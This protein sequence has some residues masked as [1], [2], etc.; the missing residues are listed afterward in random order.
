M[1]RV[2]MCTKTHQ[3]I[4]TETTKRTSVRV[5]YHDKCLY[6]KPQIAF[7][8]VFAQAI[9][10]ALYRKSS[11]TN[12]YVNVD[13]SINAAMHRK[14]VIQES[15]TVNLREKETSGSRVRGKLTVA[16]IFVTPRVTYTKEKLSLYRFKVYRTGPLKTNHSSKWSF[17]FTGED[18]KKSPGVSST[19]EIHR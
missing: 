16:S 5:I 8:L 17:I 4:N 14:Q 13:L 9:E 11:C 6:T 19:K 10:S 15:W 3:L 1:K 12:T 7:R 18:E 2:L